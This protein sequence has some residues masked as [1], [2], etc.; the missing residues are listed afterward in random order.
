MRRALLALVLWAGA[1]AESPLHEMG[2]F[3]TREMF[4]MFLPPMAYQPAD[5]VPLGRGRWRWALHHMEANTF[6]F[7]DVL[8]KNP[9][10]DA[11]G[12]V[13][14]T[15]EFVEARLA[16]YASIPMVYFFDEEIARFELEGRYGLSDRTDLWFRMAIQNHTGGVLD[17]VIE[18]FH[19]LGFEQFGRDL[20]MQN[21]ITLVV[22][23]NGR[24]TFFSDERIL[25]KPQDPVLGLTHRLVEHGP[26]SLSATVSIKPPLTRTY[27][28]YQSGWDQ[29]YGLSGAWRNQ[30]RHAFYFGAGYIRRPHGSPEYSQL[31]FRPGLG[32]HATWEYRRWG[33]VQPFLQLLWQS[34]F[35]P[36]Q[37]D[38]TFNRPSLQHDLG[39]HWHWTSRTTLTFRYLNNITHGGNTADM[40]LG[41]SLTAHL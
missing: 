9:P 14:V 38:N 36:P 11:V 29:T 26:W 18:D 30:G 3:P 27:G 20:V 24:L 31:G 23:Q 35:L 25:G 19:K 5:P 17:P 1:R 37:A 28:V 4:P 15:R 33:R 40:G 10:R 12:R 39:L 7:S 6:Q 22:A 21:Q 13:Q 2:P 34:G 8:E 16:D 41:L 32:G